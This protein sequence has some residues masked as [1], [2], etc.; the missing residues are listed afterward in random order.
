MRAV[1]E[2]R[3]ACRRIREAA[4]FLDGTPLARQGRKVERAA[5]R[6]MKVV[7]HLREADVA[8]Q[9]LASIAGGRAADPDVERARRFL[10]RRIARD[11][12]RRIASVRARLPRRARRLEARLAKVSGAQAALSVAGEH[13][14]GRLLLRRGIDQRRREAVRLG[15]SRG[16]PSP[17]GLHDL[18]VAIKR[19]RY[20]VELERD[21]LREPGASAMA[22]E[23][24]ALQD[25][26]GRAQDLADLTERCELELERLGRL[27]TRR[28]RRRAERLEALIQLV[29]A[30]REDAATVFYGAVRASALFA[31]GSLRAQGGGPT[32]T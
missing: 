3:I 31:R 5:R 8:V 32:G 13:A 24:R 21:L 17:E 4:A 2:L 7:A 30:E 14:R 6:V 12:A 29:V 16:L 11:R 22:E 19:W 25:T 20:A 28:A 18:R 27:N 1:H 10:L 23:I 15:R 26:G 9:T